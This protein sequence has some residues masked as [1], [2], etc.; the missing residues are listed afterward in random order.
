MRYQ[1]VMLK[2]LA[3]PLIKT[4]SCMN[5]GTKFHKNSSSNLYSTVAI[6]SSAKNKPKQMH[7]LKYKL[8][9]TGRLETGK[10]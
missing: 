1:A 9:A 7:N 6:P 2:L 3:I 4:N 10:V 5:L 8:L